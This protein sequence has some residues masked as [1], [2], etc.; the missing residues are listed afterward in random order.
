MAGILLDTCAVLWVSNEDPISES[1]HRAIESAAN[2]DSVFVSPISAWEIA[3]LVRKGRVVLSMAPEAWFQAMLALPGVML[4]PMPPRVLIASAFLPGK[5][6]A[7]PADRIVAATARA[8]NLVLVTRDRAL[9][10]YG[11]EGHVRVLAC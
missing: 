4:A 9:L 2:D 7:D 8:D 3:T 11:Q 10:S 5:P 6:P 1:S